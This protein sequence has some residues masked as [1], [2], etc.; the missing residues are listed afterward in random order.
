MIASASNT[1]EARLGERYPLPPQSGVPTYN[2][3]VVIC[4]FGTCALFYVIVL[5]M[6]GPEDQG[7]LE[8]E[9]AVNERA[10]SRSD[11]NRAEV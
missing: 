1:I 3:S 10:T 7:A 11:L 9:R 4:I 5:T 8:Y 2:Y 6:L